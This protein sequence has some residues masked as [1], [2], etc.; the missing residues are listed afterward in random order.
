MVVDYLAIVSWLVTLSVMT[1][2]VSIRVLNLVS[3]VVM[4]QISRQGAL[5]PEVMDGLW[6][7][8]RL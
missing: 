6:A 8:R 3:N 4:L 5:R 2:V 1:G 7:T